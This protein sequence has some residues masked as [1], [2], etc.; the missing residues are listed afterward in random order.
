MVSRLL[1]CLFLALLLVVPSVE[2]RSKKQPSDGEPQAG[3]DEKNPW[4]AESFAGLSLRGIGPALT[5]GRIIDLAVDPANRKRYY[6]AVASGGVWKTVNAGTTWSPI[7]DGETSYSIGCLALDPHNPLV[8]WVGTGENNNQRSV[9]YGDG[10]YKSID[11]G[12]NWQHMGL[13]HSEHIG[14]IVLDPR[15]SETVFVAAQGPLWKAGGDRGLYKSTDGGETWRAVL[16]V[17]EHTGVTD[18]VLDPENPDRMWAATH[19]RRRHVWT[20]INGGPG[21][22]IHRSFDGGETWEEVSQGLP[23]EEMGRI[24]LAISPVPIQPGT[25]HPLYAVIEAAGEDG[26]FY[27]SLD[28]GSTWEK[29]SDYVSGS[30]QYYQ[31][32]I[33]DPVDPHRVYSMDTFPQVTT[34]GGA[35]FRRVGQ[36]A[37]HVDEHALW[38]DPADPEY[39]LAGNDGGIYESFDRGATWHFKA[40]LP[41]T[42][43]YKI[44]VDQAA[45]FYNVY[46][47]TQDNFTL[48]GP[49]RTRYGHGIAN[50][51]WFIVLGGDGF[52][53]RVD[54]TDENIVYA[55]WQHG[56]LHRFNRRT[57]ERVEI[58]PQPED[59]DEAPRWN[60]DAP[61]L[62]SPH[63]PARLYFGS[64][65]LYRS[66]DRGNSWRSIS[67]DLTRQ[68]DR[69]ALEVM[70][71]VWGPDAVAKS[72]STSFYGNLT[73]ASESPRVENLLYSGSDDGLIQVLE[74][75]NSEWRAIERIAGVP[76]LAYTAHLEASRHADDRVYAVFNHF[77]S[78]DFQPYLL[79][80]DDRGATWRSI[81]GDLPE[82]EPTWALVEDPEDPDLLFVGTEKGVY[83]TRDGGE[84]WIQLGSGIPT[85][86]ARSL[87][88]QER[89]TDLVVGTFGRGIY[90]LDDYTPLRTADPTAPAQLFPLRRAWSYIEELPYGLRGKGFLGDSLYLAPNPP[91]GAVF[92]YW[93]K[94][95][96]ET[97]RAERLAAEKDAEE[98]EETIRYP[99]HDE[100]RAEDREREPAILLT[101]RNAEGKVVRRLEGPA[102]KGFHRVAW[103]LRLPPS[104]P[105]EL[106]SPEPSLFATPPR[107]PLAPPGTYTVELAKRQRGE[108]TVLAGAVSFSVEPL[109]GRSG[110]A[111]EQAAAH[112]FHQ[113]TADLQRAVQGAIETAG[114]ADKRLQ[115]LTRALDTTPAVESDLRRRAFDLSHRLADLRIELEGDRSLARRSVPTPISISGRVGRLLRG[116][117]ASTE[118]PTE[119]H[120]QSFA[121][122]SRAFA[123]VLDRL[124]ELVSVDLVALEQA[125]EAAGAPWTPGRL[126]QWDDTSNR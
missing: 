108:E 97:R 31:E 35:S 87:A 105:V 109:D 85:I 26:G 34:D 28:H 76:K 126:P 5:S 90:V 17:D 91:F 44:A 63:D 61:L 47:G 79:V 66:D 77:K 14:K 9:G 107:G 22:G 88:I 80:S 39:L 50:R 38:I 8:V 12:S 29:R 116:R 13:A 36:S 49:A 103:D 70:G 118:G 94:E 25:P 122:A 54:P 4:S 72:R 119:T 24:G 123:G 53:P 93:L 62:I 102:A 37:K 3:K 40:N 75:G 51:D 11:G 48:G 113:Q 111:A 124:E 82:D 98:A 6:A 16:T 19:Q 106:S 114:E 104:D 57:G 69:N 84:R 121:R 95:G 32:L 101:V 30:P 125:A 67:P 46:G 60:W 71:K 64:Q 86:A 52:Q 112:A 83:F 78:G 18:L 115:H 120:R 92:T 33:P 89:E 20:L 7:F 117:W 45:P 74:P 23:K 56:E 59:D 42:Q 10:V 110:S 100:L 55:H 21:S 15:D 81:V 2:A 96:L 68:V 1:S 73:A 27:R 99:E 43:F 65:R 58:Q 41:V